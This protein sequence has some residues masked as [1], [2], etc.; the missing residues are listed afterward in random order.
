M[1]PKKAFFTTRY[2]VDAKWMASKWIGRLIL[3]RSVVA[4]L[5]LIFCRGGVGAANGVG[6]GVVMTL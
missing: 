4:F 5:I 3:Y 6:G 2:D 1:K